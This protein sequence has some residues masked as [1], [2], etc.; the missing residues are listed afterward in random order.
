MS[1]SIIARGLRLAVAG[2]LL[3]GGVF[4]AAAEPAAAQ[5]AQHPWQHRGYAWDHRAY[6]WNHPGYDWSHRGYVGNQARRGWGHRAYGWNHRGWAW[7]H[8]SPR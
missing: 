7:S 6:A 3:A 8:R 1:R 2:A 4:V 5:A